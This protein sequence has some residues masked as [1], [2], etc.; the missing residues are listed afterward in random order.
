MHEIPPIIKGELLAQ[1]FTEADLSTLSTEGAVSID[2]GG[3]T[4]N[5]AFMDDGT[6]QISGA[7][8]NT[9][10]TVSTSIPED[11]IVMDVLAESSPEMREQLETEIR[12]LE[13]MIDQDLDGDG[14]VGHPDNPRADTTV[15]SSN[16]A[17]ST[18]PFIAG[19]SSSNSL[20]F[21]VGAAAAIGVVLLIAYLTYL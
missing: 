8:S 13:E 5:A 21:F 10:V 6:L 17:P 3:I 19:D 15:K 7:Q 16:P 14:I 18:S 20:K 1:G 2:N 11:S 4:I 9:N 12:N